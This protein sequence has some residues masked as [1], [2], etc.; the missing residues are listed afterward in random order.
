MKNIIFWDVMGVPLVIT[1][2]SEQYIASIFRV[3][4]IS[5]LET[6]AVTSNCST[7][8]TA[9]RWHISEDDII[10][11]CAV[12]DNSNKRAIGKSDFCLCEVGSGRS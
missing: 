4:I 5:E 12:L 6:L 2:V 9:T 7:M 8:R 1:D 10:H 11:S 3:K